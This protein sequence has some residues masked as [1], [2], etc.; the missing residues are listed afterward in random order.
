VFENCF[1]FEESDVFL[2]AEEKH[3]DAEPEIWIYIAY[4]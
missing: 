1:K 3:E 4:N 2:Y